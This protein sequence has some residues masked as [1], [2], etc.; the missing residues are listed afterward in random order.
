M[1][2]SRSRAVDRAWIA[3]SV[4]FLA[5]ERR[6][7]ADTPMMRLDCPE[8]AGIDIHIKDETA[9]P[10]GSLKHRLAHALFVHAICNGEI[11]PDTPVIEASSGST[12]ISEA[13]F[14]HRLGLPFVAVVPATTA[15]AKIAAIREAGGEVVAA[16]AGEDIC[17]R[18]AALAGE[19]SGWFMNQF[20]RAAEATDWRGSN[21]IAQSLFAQLSDEPHPVPRWV[22]V[23]AGTG[24]TSATIGRYI[25][26][27]P[28]LAD[29]RLCVVDPQGSAFFE[30]F[31]CGDRDAR[32]RASPVVEGIGRACVEPSF[33]PH[34]VDRMVS[35]P[36]AASVA[37][38]HWL[39]ERTGRAFGPSTGTNLIGVLLLARAMRA[40][41][42]E[43]SSVT[44]AC[45]KGERYADTIYDAAWVAGRGLDT[46]EW[47]AALAD[48]ACAAF[49]TCRTLDHDALPAG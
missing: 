22:V 35:I 4:A 20:A 42:Q 38:A 33:N 39:R 5:E 45:D 31:G 16:E 19:R 17:A 23:G 46:A 10:S 18:A 47:D 36:D 6:R 37:A 44:L 27:R 2:Q 26:L 49:P 30:A 12:A 8:L 24:G 25:R 40:R 3:E 34:V 13:W 15:P 1:L 11:G 43:G 48:P 7:A 9:H 29:V 14:A 21:N 32:G 28:D 41:G